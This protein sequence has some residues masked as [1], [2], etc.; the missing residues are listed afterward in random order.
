MPNN[1]YGVGFETGNW[2]AEN[3]GASILSTFTLLIFL[4]WK[5]N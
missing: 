2:Q 1:C 3:F 4:V 5:P